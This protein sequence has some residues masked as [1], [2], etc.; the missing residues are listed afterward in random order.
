MNGA[1]NTGRICSASAVT[2]ASPFRFSILCPL[3]SSLWE[4]IPYG[5]QVISVQ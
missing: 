2:I 3:T 5:V 4:L 1:I